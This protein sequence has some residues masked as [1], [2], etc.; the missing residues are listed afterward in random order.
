VCI[1]SMVPL[2]ITP[3]LVQS[4]GRLDAASVQCSVVQCSTVS[5]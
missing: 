1:G 5:S 3:S 4:E 2:C